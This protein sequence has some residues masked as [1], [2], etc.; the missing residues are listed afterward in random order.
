MFSSEFPPDNLKVLDPLK[1]EGQ[2]E[3]EIRTMTLKFQSASRGMVIIA[4]SSNE[5]ADKG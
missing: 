2:E 5:I 4:P 1:K 3:I